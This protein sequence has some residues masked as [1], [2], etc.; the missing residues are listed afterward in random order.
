[1]LITCWLQ[2]MSNNRIDM[3]LHRRH[4]YIKFRAILH[5]TVYPT[6]S[7]W[8]GSMQWR[9]QMCCWQAAEM[10]A[11]PVLQCAKPSR[12]CGGGGGANGHLGDCMLKMMLSQVVLCTHKCMHWACSLRKCVS[13]SGAYREKV[14]DLFGWVLF[15]TCIFSCVFCVCSRLHIKD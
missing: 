14:K 10:S 1:M 5:L 4:K 2:I 3:V 9:V 7:G 11:R 6:T 8:Y 13:F 12:G 15:S